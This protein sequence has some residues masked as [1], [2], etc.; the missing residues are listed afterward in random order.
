MSH[1]LPARDIWTTPEGRSWTNH[2]SNDDSGNVLGS[3][4]TREEVDND[5]VL[6]VISHMH[7]I[8]WTLRS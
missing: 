8:L 1:V 7:L 5:R 2:H 6:V 3:S 4:S